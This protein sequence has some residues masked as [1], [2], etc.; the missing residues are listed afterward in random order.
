[1]N[2][3]KILP[4]GGTSQGRTCGES[5]RLN[6]PQEA[7][8]ATELS[9]TGY[10]Y[11]CAPGKGTR[12]AWCGQDEG[13]SI[14]HL[15]RCDG[16]WSKSSRLDESQGRRSFQ[17]F[18]SHQPTRADHAMRKHAA[19]SPDTCSHVQVVPRS[20]KI[21]VEGQLW[22]MSIL[23]SCGIDVIENLQAKG[24]KSFDVMYFQPCPIQAMR[25]DI[26]Q[27]PIQE[28]STGPQRGMP[29]SGWAVHKAARTTTQKT[30]PDHH[31]H[32]PTNG[33]RTSTFVVSKE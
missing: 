27:N 22:M 7:S 20:L 5:L 16:S 15:L 19:M 23:V 12:P 25:S 33:L 17:T 3:A 24:R 28:L 4:K 11:T 31:N 9:S 26:H 14:K 21:L 29:Q 18:Q 8:D 1:M 2:D 30:W 32:G 6:G 10:L 13:D